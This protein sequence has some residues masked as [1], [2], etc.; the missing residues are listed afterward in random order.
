[1]EPAIKFGMSS[2]QSGSMRPVSFRASFSDRFDIATRR[3]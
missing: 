1:M 2:E 3:G